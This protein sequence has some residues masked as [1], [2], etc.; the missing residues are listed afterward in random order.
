[1]LEKLSNVWRES[2]RIGFQLKHNYVLL[3]VLCTFGVEAGTSNGDVFSS[4]NERLSYMQDVALYKSKNHLP[5]EDIEREKLVVEKAKL[6]AFEKG[7]DPDSIEGFFRAQIAV[8]KAIQFRYRA[9]FLSNPSIKEPRDL[10]QEIR[11]ALLCLGNKINHQIRSYIELNGPFES[12]Q[13]EIFDASIKIKHVT[14]SDK[15]LLFEALQKV[16][17][18]SAK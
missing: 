1:M 5:V 12:E 17:R 16:K 13:Y 11:P 4:I 15:L 7:L 6:S 9:D 8:A 18:L 10:Q 3:V 14:T 2:V